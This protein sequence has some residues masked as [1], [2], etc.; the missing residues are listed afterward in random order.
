MSS[1]YT[2]TWAMRAKVRFNL[3]DISHIATIRSQSVGKLPNFS[4]A[5][6]QSI[7]D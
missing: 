7:Y 5:I 2:V 1:N 6:Q 3:S 4:A